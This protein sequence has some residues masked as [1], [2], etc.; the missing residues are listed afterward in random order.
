M[1][2]DCGSITLAANN[3]NGSQKLKLRIED[4][5]SG[6]T[7]V[8]VVFISHFHADHVNGIQ[9]LKPKFIV[10]PV[11]T[12]Y[13]RIIFW[14]ADRLYQTGFDI[15]Y[16]ENLRKW[17]E[18]TII[19]VDHMGDEDGEVSDETRTFDEVRNGGEE[20]IASGT[21]MSFGGVPKWIYIPFNPAVDKA[22]ITKFLQ[23]LN[24]KV[25]NL[26]N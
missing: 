7:D 6:N 20:K 14:I 17:F 24:A 26:T 5:L 11:I 13:E 18:G 2:Y 1:V 19:E 4:C 9:Y 22:K 8:D 12:E 10:V 21:R 16:A 3:F 15:N 23:E 25:L